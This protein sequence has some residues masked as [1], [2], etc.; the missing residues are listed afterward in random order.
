VS[1][2]R[3]GNGYP[4]IVLAIATDKRALRLDRFLKRRR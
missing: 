2:W 1:L 4:A 3:G